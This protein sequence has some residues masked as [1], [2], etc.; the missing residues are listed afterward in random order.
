[1]NLEIK[2]FQENSFFELNSDYDI[3]TNDFKKIFGK[4]CNEIFSFF[5]KGLKTKRGYIIKSTVPINIYAIYN[6]DLIIDTRNKQFDPFRANFKIGKTSKSKS[7]FAKNLFY[8]FSLVTE[9]DESIDIELNIT[10]KH[11]REGKKFLVTFANYER[12]PKARKLCLNYHGYKCRICGFDFFEKYGEIGLNYIQVHHLIPVSSI[13][14]EYKIDP[15]RDLIPVCANCHVMLHRK[16][17]P[18]SINELKEKITQANKE[19]YTQ[20]EF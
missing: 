11:F 3:N 19:G 4:I 10:P 2:I 13:G 20:L 18:I 7:E 1:M 14:K 16:K 9:K 17:E 12:N 5:Q 15:I 8:A 6:N